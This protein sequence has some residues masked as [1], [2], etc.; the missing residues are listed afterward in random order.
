LLFIYWLTFLIVLL[1]L[2]VGYDHTGLLEGS[3]TSYLTRGI[4]DLLG[5]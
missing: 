1:C 2:R 4:L 3:G 5:S